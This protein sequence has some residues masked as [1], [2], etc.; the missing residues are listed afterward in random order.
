MKIDGIEVTVAALSLRVPVH[1]A[2]VTHSDKTSLFL[3]GLTGGEARGRDCSAHP[4]A[5][6]PDPTVENVEPS[7]VDRVATRLFEAC[8]KGELLPA[9][10]VV[11]TCIGGGS[12]SEQSVAAA[13][14]MAVLDAELRSTS[15]SLTSVLGVERREVETGELVGIPPER[16]LGALVE[17]VAVALETGAR[18]IQIGRAHV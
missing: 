13:L 18:R 8:D 17:S 6:V 9:A 10:S 16:D 12:V 4:D 1:S 5:R 2:G 3:R 7:V 14:E 15:R 11:E